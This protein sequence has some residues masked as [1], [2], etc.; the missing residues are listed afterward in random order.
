[1]S[2]QRLILVIQCLHCHICCSRNRGWHFQ[3]NIS[4]TFQH[5]YSK[6]MLLCCLP[7]PI[8]S[9]FK[10]S[11][12]TVQLLRSMARMISAWRGRTAAKYPGSGVPTLPVG[13]SARR[14]ICRISHVWCLVVLAHLLCTFS[15]G[16]FHICAREGIYETVTDSLT[17]PPTWS[18]NIFGQT[19][20]VNMERK[21]PKK[22]RKRKEVA[23]QGMW[24]CNSRTYKE[25][26]NYWPWDIKC[27]ILIQTL[28]GKW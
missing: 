20:K 28:C 25:V 4:V 26:W 14:F 5:F 18:A 16:H 21:P 12:M 10:M 3:T 23:A 9:S 2:D 27:S 13:G 1:M 6:S 19:G 24:P 15:V 11:R 17:L 22:A 8:L 7:D